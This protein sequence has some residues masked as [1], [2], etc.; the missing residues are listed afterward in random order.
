MS[1]LRYSPLPIES[2]TRLHAGVAVGP[3]TSEFL[4][5]S[6]E[7]WNLAFLSHPYELEE[8]HPDPHFTTHVRWSLRMVLKTGVI[9]LAETLPEEQKF[10]PIMRLPAPRVALLLRSRTSWA[11]RLPLYKRYGP[12]WFEMVAERSRL[13]HQA[14]DPEESITDLSFAQQVLARIQAR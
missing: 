13:A 7:A 14:A 12:A 3:A 4:S 10:A 6:T 11:K 5:E 9:D 2:Y 8:I 1:T